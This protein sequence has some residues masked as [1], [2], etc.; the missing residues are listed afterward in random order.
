M[1]NNE[2]TI[3]NLIRCVI[4]S[5]KPKQAKA[6]DFIRLSVIINGKLFIIF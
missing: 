2:N 6:I 5:S 4:E 1:A 3:Q